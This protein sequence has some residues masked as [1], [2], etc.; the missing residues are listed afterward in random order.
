MEASNYHIDQ[1][2]VKE[3]KHNKEAFYVKI[4]QKRT[5]KPLVLR[6]IYEY[7]G[8]VISYESGPYDISKSYILSE[9]EELTQFGKYE[10]FTILDATEER[11]Q[12]QLNVL[13]IIFLFLDNLLICL[14]Y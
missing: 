7:E 6:G 3:F 9:E 14:K 8:K 5:L 4:I 1:S 12:F 11:P 2:Y 13:V 10:I